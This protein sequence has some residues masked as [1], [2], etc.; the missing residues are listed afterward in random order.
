MSRL[1]ST[2][3]PFCPL[4]LVTLIMTTLTPISCYFVTLITTTLT[5]VSC[6]FGHDYPDSCLLL[7]LSWPSWH[8]SLV[9]FI[10]TTLSSI[11]CWLYLLPLCY[12]SL[13]DFTCYHSVIDLL[14]TSLVTILSSICCWLYLLLPVWPLYRRSLIDV[15]CYF[16][17][18]MLLSLLS[19]CHRSLLSC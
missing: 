10:L 18:D 4:P 14:L 8:L 15:T 9:T 19:P 5:P 16:H 3:Y 2:S 13:V 6:Y 17:H 12:R 11:P 7:L 1:L